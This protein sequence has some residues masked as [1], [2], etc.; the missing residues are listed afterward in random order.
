MSKPPLAPVRREVPVGPPMPAPTARF[1]AATRIPLP[2]HGPE[3]V[4]VGIDGMLYLGVDGGGIVRLDPASHETTVVATTSGRPLGLQPLPDGR[5]LV[6]DS[7]KGLLRVDPADGSV[8]T[9]VREVGTPLTFCSNVVVQRDGTIWFTESTS[10]FTF[11]HFEGAFLEHR[12]AGR[13]MRLDT[14]GTVTVVLDGLYFA[15]GLTLL[16]DESALVFVETGAYAI[17]R[18]LLTGPRQGSVETVM[19]DLTGYPDN[20][21]AVIDGKIWVAMA[22]PRSAMADRAGVLPG[23]IRKL[24]WALPKGLL[25]RGASMAWVMAFDLDG[26]VVHDFHEQRADFYF[27]T[28]VTE[29]DGKL[30]VASPEFDYLLCLELP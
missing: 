1:P 4:V 17:R 29:L 10:R 25:P 3:D 14:D 30:Y 12:A 16:P 21:S 27:T 9:L 23:W 26:N 13:L 20:L 15:N 5:L 24:L 19:A 11:F 6:C 8:E 7:L 18:L 28:G 2:G 22:G